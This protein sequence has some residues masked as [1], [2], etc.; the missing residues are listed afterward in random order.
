MGE[1]EIS[2]PSINNFGLLGLDIMSDHAIE[3]DGDVDIF[4][5]TGGR[6]PEHITHA[7]IDECVEEIEDDAFEVC[8]NL[9]HVETHNR[10]RKIGEY[11]FNGCKSL[12]RI[13]IK[14]VVE[15]DTGGFNGCEKL[16]FIEFGDKLESIGHCAFCRCPIEHLKLPSVVGINTYAF[17][18]SDHLIDVEFSE[19][20]ESVAASA[21]IFCKRLQRIAIPLKRNLLEDGTVFNGCEQ[22][23]RVDLVGG[24]HQTVASFQMESWRSEMVSDFNRINQLLP[25]TSLLKTSVIMEWMDSVIGRLE[26]YKTEHAN[27]VKEGMTLLELALWKA[28]LDQKDDIFEESA[29]KEVNTD[30]E[31]VRKASRVTCGADTVIKNVLPFLLLK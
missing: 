7:R 31:D 16:R 3:D 8:E 27:Y 5:Y 18:R 29:T 22:L 11:A 25:D 20:L 17:V 24:V 9:V 13:D 4:V 19:K 21:F 30:V 2:G 12:P 28:N 23:T 6:A 14:S 15:I 1:G 26:H 10:I